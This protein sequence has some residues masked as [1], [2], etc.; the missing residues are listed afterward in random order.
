MLL[1][2]KNFAMKQICK[3][4]SLHWCKP[5]SVSLS[6]AAVRPN[7]AL[8]S[9]SITVGSEQIQITKNMYFKNCLKVYFSNGF[10]STHSEENMV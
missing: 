9:F 7:L 1:N 6:L 10:F 3:A 8:V 5:P 2:E 4:V